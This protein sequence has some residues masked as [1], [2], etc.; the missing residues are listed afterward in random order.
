MRRPVKSTGFTLIE[1]MV[2]VAIAAILA[3]LA[4]PSFRSLM[5]DNQISSATNNMLGLIHAS[6]SEAI[7]QHSF[8]R[9]CGSSNAASDQASYSCNS[10][11]WES[12]VIAFRSPDATTT[13]ASKAALVKVIPPNAG[14]ITLRSSGT[15]TFTPNGTLSSAAT[16]RVCDSRGTAKSRAVT[17]NIAGLAASGENDTCP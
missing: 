6:R 3:S 5:L 1:L 11:N 16:L 9:V 8:I 12:G 10:N 2:V 4:I 17:V 14:G 13:T 15:I 7:T